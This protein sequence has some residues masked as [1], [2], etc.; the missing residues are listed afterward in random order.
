MDIFGKKLIQLLTKVIHKKISHKHK[1]HAGTHVG[2]QIAGFFGQ[3]MWFNPS[4]IL[5][6]IDNEIGQVLGITFAILAG[7]FALAKQRKWW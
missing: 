6:Y 7:V 3:I 2:C 5:E 1:K 4:G